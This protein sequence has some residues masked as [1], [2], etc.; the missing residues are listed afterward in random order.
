[1]LIY[2]LICLNWSDVHIASLD[3]LMVLFNAVIALVNV[4]EYIY[5]FIFIYILIYIML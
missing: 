1:M 2:L 5:I 3:K 4:N